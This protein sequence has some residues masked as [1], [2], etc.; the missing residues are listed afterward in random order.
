MFLHW[1]R[2]NEDMNMVQNKFS[3]HIHSLKLLN[4][5]NIVLMVDSTYQTNKYKMLLLEPLD[6]TSMGLTF[7]VAFVLLVSKHKNNFVCH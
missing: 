5:F 4:L 1:C 2:F 7:F 3:T 6:D